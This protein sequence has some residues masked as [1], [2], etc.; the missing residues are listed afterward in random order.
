MDVT[1]TIA[2]SLIFDTVDPTVPLWPGVILP[3]DFC[4]GW[5]SALDASLESHVPVVIWGSTVS[6]RVSRVRT[7][8][9]SVRVGV[10]ITCMRF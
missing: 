4:L 8:R 3:A 7:V 9:M 5:I 2:V 10:S 1:G 6:G